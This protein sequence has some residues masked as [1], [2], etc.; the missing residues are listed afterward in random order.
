[1]I[2]GRGGEEKGGE[3]R[4]KRRWDRMNP[5]NKS[6]LGPGGLPGKLSNI[7]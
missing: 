4:K 5:K 1:M 6:C 3:E 7:Y 2:K